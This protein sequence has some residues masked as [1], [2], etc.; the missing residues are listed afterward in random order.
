MRI[1][2]GML[3]EPMY[4]ENPGERIIRDILSVKETQSFYT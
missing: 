4:D 3:T 1:S 2:P